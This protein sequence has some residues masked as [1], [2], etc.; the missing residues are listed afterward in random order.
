M[1]KNLFFF[2][3]SQ[4]IGILVLLVLIILTATINFALPY[5][6]KDVDFEMDAETTALFEEFKASLVC[7]DSLKAAERNSMYQNKYASHAFDKTSNQSYEY[8][9]FNPNN[10]DSLGFI[11][12]GLRPFAISNIL[13]YRAQGGEF[14]IKADFSKIYGVSQDKFEELYAYLNLPEKLTPN[15]AKADF[16]QEVDSLTIA[17]SPIIIV[18]LNSA[19]TTEL[20]QIKGIGKGYARSIIKFRQQTG[21]F[22]DV[23][24][25]LEI[26]GMTQENYDRIKDFCTVDANLINPINI[27][28]ASIERLKSHPYLNFYKAKQIYELRRKQGKLTN[29][30]DLQELSEVNDSIIQRI[31]PYFKFE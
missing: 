13:K 15:E 22:A 31:K 17:Q 2:S 7:V 23:E 26:Y 25:L 16:Q 24:Q 9:P 30:D 21:G 28:T 19:D 14:K 5:F 27:N 4:R 6:Q 29:W 20:M 8:F 3:L 12:L 11:S 10:L 1:W 18:E